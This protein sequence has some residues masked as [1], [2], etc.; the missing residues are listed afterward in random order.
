MTIANA[1]IIESPK[2][3]DKVPA[4][5]GSGHPRS[6]TLQQIKEFVGEGSEGGSGL[7]PPM[8]IEEYEALEEKQ[9]TLYFIIDLEGVERIYYGTVL[10]ARR[11]QGGEDVGTGFPYVFPII[12][13]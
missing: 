13:G 6:L 10:I 12:F 8:S 11:R 3:A 4:S 5:D 1:P 7:L 9:Q 2:A